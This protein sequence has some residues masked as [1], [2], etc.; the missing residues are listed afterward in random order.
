[1]KLF[2]ILARKPEVV[3]RALRVALVVGTAPT[4]INQPDQPGRPADRGAGAELD[5]DGSDLSDPLLR[6]DDGA[7]TAMRDRSRGKRKR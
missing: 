6:L 7:V 5:Q 3:A 4:L 1:M 2:F